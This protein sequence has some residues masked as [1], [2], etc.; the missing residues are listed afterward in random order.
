[1]EL[2]KLYIDIDFKIL[3][4]KLLIISIYTF[5]AM[6]KN[7]CSLSGLPITIPDF[8]FSDETADFPVLSSNS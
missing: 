7:Y 4:I 2:V 3:I 1:M 5:L 8:A 6:P